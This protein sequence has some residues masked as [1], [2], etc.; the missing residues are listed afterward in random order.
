MRARS[1]RSW[2]RRAC[3]IFIAL[4]TPSKCWR[5]P[6][7]HR[8]STTG[9]NPMFL[10]GLIIGLVVM[11]LLVGLYIWLVARPLNRWLREY[12]Q[13]GA[14]TILLWPTE[15]KIGRAH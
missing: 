5:K 12:A 8:Y 9:G 3:T 2:S 15:V 11:Y 14:S 4:Q 7:R 6:A 13:I 10:L 1:F